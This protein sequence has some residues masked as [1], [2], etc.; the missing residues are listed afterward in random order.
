MTIIIIIPAYIIVTLY[1]FK[2]HLPQALFELGQPRIMP[3]LKMK[4]MRHS[5]V[6]VKLCVRKREREMIV[7]L[8]N[9]CILVK[10]ANL[11]Q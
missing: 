11:Q 9:N 3:I 7:T 4:K 5:N 2:N 1:H 10:G 8:M 6:F